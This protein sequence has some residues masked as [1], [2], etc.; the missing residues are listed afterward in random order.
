M[1]PYGWQWTTK[2]AL[3]GGAAVVQLPTSRPILEKLTVWATGGQR[4][5]AATSFQLRVNGVNVGAAGTIGAGVDSDVVIQLEDGTNGSILLPVPIP[6]GKGNPATPPDAFA[7]DISI[8]GTG[9]QEVTLYMAGI[10]YA[11]GG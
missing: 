11:G 6:P 1:N 10:G 2:V 9:A 4:T 5:I 3:V 8:A 7:V